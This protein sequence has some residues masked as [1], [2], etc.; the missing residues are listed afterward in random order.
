[1]VPTDVD[2]KEA[3]A[4]LPFRLLAAGVFLLMGIVSFY[5]G[6]QLLGTSESIALS[7]GSRGS[8]VA[9]EFGRALLSALPVPLQSK[10]LGFIGVLVSVFCFWL[11]LLL[12]KVTRK[13]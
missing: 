8:R 7:C 13:P 2:P 3:A 12:C 9:C 4:R 1:M 5:K 6:A 11:T 10:V